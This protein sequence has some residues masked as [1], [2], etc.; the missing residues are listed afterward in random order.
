MRELF[1]KLRKLLDD[2]C[3]AI[4]VL[5][6]FV[7]IGVI[8]VSALALEYG[9]GLLQRVENQRVA[10]LAAYGG[11]LVYGST[12]STSSATRA[13]NNIVALNG[14]SGAGTASVVS[15]PTGD[16][17]QAVKATV[18]SNIPLLLARVLTTKTTMP[19]SATSYAE[20]KANAPGCIVALNGAGTG[21]TVS[22][23]AI[24]AAPGCAVASNST[25]TAHACSNII[26]TEAVDYNG[27][28]PSPTCAFQTSGG[29]TPPMNNVWT[30]DPLGASSGSPGSTEVTNATSRISTVSSLASPTAPSGGSGT[31][32]LKLSS[33]SKSGSLPS[34][35]TMTSTGSPWAITCTGTGPFY[36]GAFTLGGSSIATFTNTSSGATYYFSGLID[37]GTSGTLTFH[38]GSG[39]TYNMAAGIVAHGTSPFS[40]D[41]G[42]FNMGPTSSS[43]CPAAGYS[44]C[45]SGS[46]RITFGGPSR[47][48][49]AGGIYQGASGMPPT[50]G[51]SFGYGSTTN[52]F[53][54]GKSSTGN[55]SL[56]EANG[57][58]L[59]GDATGSSDLFQM[60]GNLTTS[61]GTCV[62]VSAAAEH[63]IN[64]SIGA[65]GGIVL[66]AGIYTING[67][68]AVGN[69]GGGNVSNCPATGTT[70]GL[71]GL[72]VTLVVSGASTVSCGGTTS[73]FCLGAGY[74]TVDL[75]APT[76]SST[77]GGSTANL[78]VVGPQSSTNTAA[79]AFTTG[80]TNTRISGAFCFPHGAVTMS[81][82]A[83]LHDTVDTNACLELIGSQVTLS[84][85]SAAGTSCVG[86]GSGSLGTTVSLVQ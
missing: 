22:G 10:D 12:S 41:A 48:T 77:L 42:T 18:T 25:V 44:I 61:G 47:F 28:V 14:L 74:S 19:V 51:L 70:T 54:I 30:T 63:D 81:G 9:H 37:S 23:G 55:Y 1:G 24:V 49:L 16:G 38:G 11:A 72:G 21:V 68:V 65:A 76:S 85:G 86:L 56:N 50:P 6:S 73:A 66:G 69:G 80:A 53:N 46:A 62:A 71:T 3:G 59:F 84:A 34:G 20:I 75:T 78:A 29:G 8:G 13:V 83:T 35:C 7:L 60:A 45:V 5:G 4:G 57:A 32:T 27:A 2:V 43:P 67:Y 52:S 82:A 79:A 58:T 17:N 33:G 64:G 15:S 31:G 36:F 40:F 39:A 26:T